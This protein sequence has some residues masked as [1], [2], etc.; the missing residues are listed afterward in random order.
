[1][2]LDGQVTRHYQRNAAEL[3][4]RHLIGVLGIVNLIT[5]KPEL[6]TEQ[7][8][9]EIQGTLQRQARLGARLIVGDTSISKVAQASPWQSDRDTANTAPDSC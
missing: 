4:T 7:L 2:T 6:S 1:M 8:I 5:L 3:A 9:R